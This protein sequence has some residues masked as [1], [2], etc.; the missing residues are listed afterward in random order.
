MLNKTFLF[1]VAVLLFSSCKNEE[2][3]SGAVVKEEKE[4]LVSDL[5]W[6]EGVWVDSTSFKMIGQTYVEAWDKESEGLFK[7]VKYAVKNGV[8]GDTTLMRIEKTEDLFYLTI[9]EGKEKGVF[10]Q[11][12]GLQGELKFSNT[13]DEFP[14]DVNYQINGGNL[15]IT[16]SGNLNGGFKK[17]EYNTFKK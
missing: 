5:D 6:I 4:V 15:L 12:T 11:Q 17:I 13:K 7:G 2:V 14:Y 1:I 3:E 16:V 8:N 10:M 9:G